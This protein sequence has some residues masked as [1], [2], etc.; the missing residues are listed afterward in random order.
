MRFGRI[1]RA[2]GI[3]E[4]FAKAL[5]AR[6]KADQSVEA[7]RAFVAAYV[8]Y[9]HYVEG[10]HNAVMGASVHPEKNGSHNAGHS[11]EKH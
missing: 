4:H 1:P 5:Q 8:A 7:G 6:Q 10:L 3:R 9:V 2:A 11:T